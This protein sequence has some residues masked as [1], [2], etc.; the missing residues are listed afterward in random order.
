MKKGSEPKPEEWVRLVYGYLARSN[1]FA[2]LVQL[3][4][5]TGEIDSVNVP[6][7]T[8]QYPNWRRKLA[9]LLE[10]LLGKPPGKEIV[11]IFSEQR[12]S[13]KAVLEKATP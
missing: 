7:S 2:V 13:A 11:R 10:E 4:D 5:I 6:G 8:D 1:S 9:V 12:A 3:E